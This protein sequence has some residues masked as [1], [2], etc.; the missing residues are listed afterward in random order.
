MDC[1]LFT[2][3]LKVSDIIVLFFMGRNVFMCPGWLLTSYVEQ[4]LDLHL[5]IHV[6]KL[7]TTKRGEH[8]EI[9]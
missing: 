9:T 1:V 8:N 6:N 7:A 5:D 2:T 3:A 4:Q